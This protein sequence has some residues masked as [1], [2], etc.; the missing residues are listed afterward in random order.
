MDV[1]SRNFFF[2]TFILLISRVVVILI[3]VYKILADGCWTAL[4][5]IGVCEVEVWSWALERE[6]KPDE[7]HLHFHCPQPCYVELSCFNDLS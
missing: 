1:G 2:C 6:L 7:A 5:H 4:L 3:A